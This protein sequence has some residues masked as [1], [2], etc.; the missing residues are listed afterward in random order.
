MRIK[1]MVVDY[2]FLEKDR[3]WR[4]EVRGNRMSNRENSKFKFVNR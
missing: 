1:N 2:R 4:G 3:S